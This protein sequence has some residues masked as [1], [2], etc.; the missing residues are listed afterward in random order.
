MN[1]KEFIAFF[2][3]LFDGECSENLTMETEF[4]YLDE[5]SS[6]IGLYLLTDMKEK[7]G[8]NIEVQEF[9]E[10]ETLDDLYKLYLRK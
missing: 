9:K 3:S 6:L 10:C 1:D 8:K 5:W 7:Y 4:R 2:S